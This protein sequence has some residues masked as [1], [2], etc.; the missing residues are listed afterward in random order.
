MHCTTSSGPR[1]FLL[2]T[3]FMYNVT[4]FVR[5]FFDYEFVILSVFVSHFF[6]LCIVSFIKKNNGMPNELSRDQPS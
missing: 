6:R 3:D 4:F 5:V 2:Q 1:L